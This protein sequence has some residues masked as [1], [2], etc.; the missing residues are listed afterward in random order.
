VQFDLI[1]D[2]RDGTVSGHGPGLD[3]WD[4]SLGGEWPGLAGGGRRPRAPRPP[5]RRHPDELVVWW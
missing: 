1:V 5:D 2:E 3:Q 4:L